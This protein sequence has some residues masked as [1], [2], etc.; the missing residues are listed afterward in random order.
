MKGLLLNQYYS[1]EKTIWTYVPLGLILA[2]VLIFFDNP[3]IQRLAAFLPVIF[4]ASSALE[5]LKHES[6]SGW[7]KYVLT[8]PVKRSRVVQSHYLFFSVLALTGL[9]I[10]CIAFVL[11]Q[12]VFGQT[13]SAG[14]IY[15]V[16]NILGMTCTMGFVAYPLT[17][18]L[19]TEKAEVVAMAGMIAGLGVF[20]LSAFVYDLFITPLDVL[21]GLNQDLLFS[22]SFLIIN[23]I[24]LVVSY[25]I[26]IQIY[27]RKEF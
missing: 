25:V 23:F 15:S 19:G 12:F 3:V 16:M 10:A 20:F 8:L 18:L 5:V 14:Y 27:K 13:P 6:K 9:L 1:V 26:S 22:A 7:N 4:M 17:Y 11:A 21:Q 24:L 2:T